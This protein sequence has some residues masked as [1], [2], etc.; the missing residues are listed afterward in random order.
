MAK[1]LLEDTEWF[2]RIDGNGRVTIEEK[3]DDI[4]ATFD[5]LDRDVIMPDLTDETDIYDIPNVLRVRDGNGN[6]ETIYNDDENSDTSIGNIGWEKWEDRQLDLDY[7]ETLLE[8][9]NKQMEEMSKTK[10]KISYTREFDP[11]I[12]TNDM[13]LYLLPHQG[14]VGV[15]RI[16][17]Q[18]ISIGAGVSVSEIAEFETDNWRA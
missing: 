11:D 6:Y 9:A 8:K 12:K 15:F 4:V 13:V 1:Y 14:I 2:I 17:S 7:G 5:T 3:S 18:S 16:I 10:R